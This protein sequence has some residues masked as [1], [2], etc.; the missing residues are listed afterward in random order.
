MAYPE[1]NEQSVYLTAGAALPSVI[2]SA[3]NALLTESF[4]GAYNHM[5]NIVRN[6][7]YALSDIVTS[8]SVLVLRLEIPDT[9]S[10][11]LVDKLSTIEFHLS[12]GISE[13]LQLGSLVGAFIVAR[14]MMTPE[15]SS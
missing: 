4:Q 1:V 7:G 9:V 15:K 6:F 12:H 10:A 13:K 5:M 11:H 8:L 14:K 3:L 2:D